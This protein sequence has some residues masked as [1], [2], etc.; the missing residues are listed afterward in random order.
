MATPVSWI[1]FL[2]HAESETNAGLDQSQHTRHT[3][4]TPIGERQARVVAKIL[5]KE[6]FDL[7]IISPFQRAQD[8]AKPFLD[9]HGRRVP[10]VTWP[11][12]EFV[13]HSLG[14][15]LKRTKA[16]KER[17][18]RHYWR[19]RLDP[20]YRESAEAET[21]RELIARIERTFKRLIRDPHRKIL[22]VSHGHFTKHLIWRLLHPHVAI[23]AKSMADARDF[24]WGMKIKNT[25]L[26]KIAKIDKRLY[27]GSIDD[28]HVVLT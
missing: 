1:Y 19:Q 11:V 13:Y 7:V 6:K 4:L 20:D 22:V 3:R 23:D 16:A 2:R 28:Q 5:T 10:V 24:T 21:Y 27:V 14:R 26:I 18:A 25:A 8:T 17:A 9:C 15:G 12:Q